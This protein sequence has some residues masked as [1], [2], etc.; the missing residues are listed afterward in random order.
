L[1][2]FF[3]AKSAFAEISSLQTLMRAL[4]AAL[5]REDCCLMEQEIRKFFKKNEQIQE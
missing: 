3:A 5:C 2:L 4:M 1:H